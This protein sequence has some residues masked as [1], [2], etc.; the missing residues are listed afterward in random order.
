MNTASPNMGILTRNVLY[1]FLVDN[2]LI[3]LVGNRGH[4]SPV[5]RARLRDRGTLHPA[6]S[7]SAGALGGICGIIS[8]S[9]VGHAV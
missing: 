2:R 5:L 8:L 3:P 7:E 1:T 4:A 6:D 9:S